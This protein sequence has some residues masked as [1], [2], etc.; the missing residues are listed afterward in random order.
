M[1]SWGPTLSCAIS[2]MCCNE[3]CFEEVELYSYSKIKM[4]IL[5]SYVNN[6]L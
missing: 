2:K 5:L 1:P 3:L 4:Y 6:L